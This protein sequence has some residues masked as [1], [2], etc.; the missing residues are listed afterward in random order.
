VLD[1][2]NGDWQEQKRKWSA[3]GIQGELGRGDN[4]IDAEDEADELR[5]ARAASPGGNHLPAM[6]YSKSGAKGDG[7][8]RALDLDGVRKSKFGKCLETGI[9][10]A[11]GRKE[12]NGTSIFD[13]VLCE[14]TY[15]WFSKPGDQVVDRRN[16]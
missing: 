11:Y 3:L 9:G 7:R 16:R 14:L 6:D 15:R 10:E 2:K 12:M 4:F 8:G 13:P 1:A 5:K